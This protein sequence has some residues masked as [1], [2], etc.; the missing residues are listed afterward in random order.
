MTDV[1][2]S[3]GAYEAY[4]GTMEP[5]RRARISLVARCGARVWRSLADGTRR[6]ALRILDGADRPRIPRFGAVMGESA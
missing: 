6:I 3:G 1:W 5:A 4:I 2:A